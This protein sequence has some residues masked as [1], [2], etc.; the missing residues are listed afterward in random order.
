MTL[1][2]GGWSPPRA[3]PVVCRPPGMTAWWGHPSRVP[4]VGRQQGFPF[5][6]ECGTPAHGRSTLDQGAD[7]C[8]GYVPGTG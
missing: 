4:R 8:A 7:R 6:L 3:T 2:A 5:V 1:N